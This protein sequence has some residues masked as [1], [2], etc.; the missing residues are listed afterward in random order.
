VPNGAGSWL[1]SPRGVARHLLPAFTMLDKH[2][3]SVR[4]AKI[5]ATVLAA[6]AVAPFAVAGVLGAVGF[7]AAGVVGGS[8]L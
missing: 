6:G 8:S 5:G 3:N 7:G 2:P 4:V 1:Q